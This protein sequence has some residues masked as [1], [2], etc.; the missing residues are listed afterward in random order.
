MAEDSLGHDL[1][2]LERRADAADSRA[3]LLLGVSGLL[4]SLG[5][6]G[7]WVPLELSARFF[8]GL[9]ALAA[10]GAL[11]AEVVRPRN[12]ARLAALASEDPALRAA[13][14]QAETRSYER[15]RTSFEVKLARLRLASRLV[16]ASLAFAILGATVDG[17]V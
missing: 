6:S 9:A 3:G 8:A 17:V 4:A 1:D 15:D 2:A 12:A 16:T 14:M 10:V 13:A 7:G 11:S 5:D